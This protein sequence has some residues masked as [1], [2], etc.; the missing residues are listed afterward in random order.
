MAQKLR[1]H[2]RE[3]WVMSRQAL[4]PESGTLR[5]LYNWAWNQTANLGDRK[6]QS[7]STKEGA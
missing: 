3:S 7:Y 6:Q 1:I 5:P 4:L 2:V